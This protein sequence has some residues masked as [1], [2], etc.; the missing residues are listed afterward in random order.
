MSKMER[1]F[2]FFFAHQDEQQEAWLRAMAR[3]GLH[4]EDVNPFCFWTFRRGEPA[5]L[6]YRV[7]Y[8]TASQD[9]GFKQLMQDAG[10]ALAATTVGWH[11][12][13]TRAVDGRAPELFSDRESKLRKFRNRLNV[14]IG[15][16]LPAFIILMMSNKQ[17]AFEQLSLPF[18]VPLCVV[19]VLYLTI[20]PYTIVQLMLR[21][22]KLNNPLPT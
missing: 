13:C 6:V 11:Y 9:P 10:W 16:A 19:W 12:W 7:D 5:D 15:S 17:N 2:K 20:M 3:Q 4:L 1:R 22:R 21:I 14:V 18:L 8:P